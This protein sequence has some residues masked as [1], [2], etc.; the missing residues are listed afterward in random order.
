MG[1][2]FV[3]RGEGVCNRQR[4]VAVI[5]VAW[6]G[7]RLGGALDGTA[8][9]GWAQGCCACAVVGW[10]G[11]AQDTGTGLSLV[12]GSGFVASC[13]SRRLLSGGRR[14]GGGCGCR[15]VGGVFGDGLFVRAG[16]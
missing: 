13:L 9:L 5:F 12:A 4:L 11:A 15:G 2:G 1:N 10:H 14:S 6:C 16:R 8:L 3:V 7:A